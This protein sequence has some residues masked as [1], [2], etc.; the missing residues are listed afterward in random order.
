MPHPCPADSHYDMLKDLRNIVDGWD[1]EP[2]RISVR[3]IIGKRG[4][5]RI[6]TRIDL[7]VLQMLLD[8]R[9]DGERPNGHE[10]LIDYFDERV[11][12]HVELYGDDDD[13][14]L[15]GEDCQ[16]LRHEA[17]L[18]YQ[19][20]LSLFVLEDYERVVRDTATNLR[21][22]ELCEQYAV[23]REDRLAMSAQRTYVTMMNARARAHLALEL[24]EAGRA[25]SAVDAG[26]RSVAALG[27]ANDAADAPNI[28]GEMR[29]LRE[30][31]QQV[32]E[33]LPEQSPER[34]EWQLREALEAEDYEAAA[35]LR[36]ALADAHESAELTD[37]GGPAAS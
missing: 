27:R 3:K 9:P 18:Y 8:G 35:R 14:V 6:Q 20:Y 29:I 33:N 12:R 36:D 7:G 23:A 5:E 17:Y 30:L 32:L 22:I 31:R 10:S 25:L 37:D 26:L 28:A 15:S 24:G 4:E 1:Y 21:A 11:R 19:R 34:L 13:F 16:E 2:G